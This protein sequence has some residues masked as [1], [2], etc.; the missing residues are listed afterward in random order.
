MTNCAFH[1]P[2]EG[3]LKSGMPAFVDIPAPHMMTMFL[4][5]PSLSPFSKSASENPASD[6]DIINSKL[7]YILKSCM[8][9]CTGLGKGNHLALYHSTWI[10]AS[11]WSGNVFLILM[12]CQWNAMLGNF[13]SFSH[14]FSESYLLLWKQLTLC[15]HFGYKTLPTDDFIT[16]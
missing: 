4:N 11:P 12:K 16:G 5:L 15:L 10:D 14:L 13:T 6:L 9:H 7:K 3:D 8:H 2:A 1:S